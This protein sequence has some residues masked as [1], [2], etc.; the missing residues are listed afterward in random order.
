MIL[1]H[2]TRD[3]VFLIQYKVK[4]CRY[5]RNGSISQVSRNIQ[6]TATAKWKSAIIFANTVCTRRCR[7]YL[8]KYNSQGGYA[9]GNSQCYVIYSHCN[10]N[11]KLS[12]FNL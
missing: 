9:Q 10:G 7:D 6:T 2:Y 5:L 4:L 1:L 12:V 11:S 8:A 3:S